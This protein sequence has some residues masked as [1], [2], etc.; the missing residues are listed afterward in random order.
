MEHQG[1]VVRWDRERGLGVL[2]SSTVEGP[3][4]AHYSMIDENSRGV[5]EAGGFRALAVGDE[6]RFTVEQAE[7]DGYHWRAIWICTV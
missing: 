1:K 6:V 2:E 5:R 4:W 7:Q 3:V